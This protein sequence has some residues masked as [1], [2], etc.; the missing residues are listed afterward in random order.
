VPNGGYSDSYFVSLCA[1][2]LVA[3]SVFEDY[4]YQGACDQGNHRNI[5][6]IESHYE[7]HIHN[8]DDESFDEN[9]FNRSNHLFYAM[10]KICM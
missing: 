8:T 2:P 4:M 10:K 5:Q 6:F 1:P 9:C 3:T 7:N